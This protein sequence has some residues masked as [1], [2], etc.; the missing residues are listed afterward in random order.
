MLSLVATVTAVP[1][2]AQQTPLLAADMVTTIPAKEFAAKLWADTDLYCTYMCD[3]TKVDSFASDPLTSRWA[4]SIDTACPKMKTEFNAK[5]FDLDTLMLPAGTHLLMYGQSYL[6]ELFSTIRAAYAIKGGINSTDY[7]SDSPND[8]GTCV[9]AGGTKQLGQPFCGGAEN[10]NC[11]CGDVIR[12]HL[13]GG[14][15]ITGIFNARAYQLES[16]ASELKTFIEGY[17]YTTALVMEPHVKGFFGSPSVWDEHKYGCGWSD[18]FW[19]LWNEAMPGKVK[20]VVP[21]G[22][23]TAD[24][25]LASG[26]PQPPLYTNTRQLNCTSESDYFRTKLNKEMGIMGHQCL[27]ARDSTGDYVGPVPYIAADLVAALK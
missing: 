14:S 7:L 3:Y 5:E 4:Y 17:K 22:Y 2:E 13:S 24:L 8:V 10:A 1:P 21:W 9:C 19:S 11:K 15:S 27:A 16:Q 20:H 26:S 25:A 6:R 18:T 23:E 12:Y